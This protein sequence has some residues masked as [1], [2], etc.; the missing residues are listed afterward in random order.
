MLSALCRRR[1]PSHALAIVQVG[2]K[3]VVARAFANDSPWRWMKPKITHRK[4]HYN[5]VLVMADVRK[6]LDTAQK[7]LGEETGA[8]PKAF[9]EIFAKRTIRTMH[10]FK[11]LELAILAR[12]FDAHD[13][14]RGIH[15]AV[16][17]RVEKTQGFP[18]IAIP[19]LADILVRR[20][21]EP[22]ASLE[23]VARQACNV[24]W[25]L[26]VTDLLRLLR[27][28]TAAG[29]R[30]QPLCGRAAR[31]VLVQID[32]LGPVELGDVAEV[33]AGQQHRDLTLFRVLAK[34]F[35][36]LCGGDPNAEPAALVRVVEGFEA[37][38]IEVPE[39]LRRTGNA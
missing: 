31:K 9:W 19:V 12:A 24:M 23:A 39:M 22:R 21:E 20:V 2:P 18:G 37:L 16:A 25:E 29:V 36:G 6:L 33:F 14:D 4:R 10:L 17:A 35:V 30:N 5:E 11:P 13:V 15:S 32:S 38:E 27:S 3:A 26:G 7:A 1:L 34:R 28:L 8:F